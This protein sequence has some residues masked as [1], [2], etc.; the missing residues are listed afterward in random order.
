MDQFILLKAGWNVCGCGNI[1]GLSAQAAHLNTP[2]L[3]D[4]HQAEACFLFLMHITIAK[5][6]NAPR[7]AAPNVF[8]IV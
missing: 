2:K 3:T 1:D 7:A 5:I 8:Q 6:S 4:V